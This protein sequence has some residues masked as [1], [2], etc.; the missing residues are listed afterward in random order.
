MLNLKKFTVTAATAIC[1]ASAPSSALAMPAPDPSVSS[2]PVT[3]I[4]AP[5][6]RATSS[7]GFD[8]GD[9]GIGAAG[10][11]VLIGIG[12]VAV[13]GRRRAGHRPAIG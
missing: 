10:M 1:L 12:S 2:A 4:Q 13:S 5:A 9:A 11:L 6:Q 3:Q 7:N 8:V